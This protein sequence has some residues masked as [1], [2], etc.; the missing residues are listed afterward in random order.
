MIKI[1]KEVFLK[2]EKKH[3]KKLVILFSGSTLSLFLEFFTLASLLPVINILI[4][5]ENSRI[6]Y[7][8][9]DFSNIPLVISIFVSAIL[10]STIY[11]LW[12][13]KVSSKAIFKIGTEI[14]DNIFRKVIRQKYL[15]YKKFKSE[16]F[17]SSITK[18]NSLIGGIILPALLIFFS[19]LMVIGSFSFLFLT[20]NKSLII[21]CLFYLSAY[22]IFAYFVRKKLLDNGKIIAKREGDRVALSQTALGDIRNI[23]LNNSYKKVE[24]ENY[25]MSNSQNIAKAT[26][27]FI[28]GSPRYVMEAVLIIIISIFLLRD[29][30]LL[31]KENLSQIAIL[32][33]A[34][35]RVL[36]QIQAFFSNWAVINSN[37]GMASDLI[38]LL[39]LEEEEEF[40]EKESFVFD[41]NIEDELQIEIN[42]ISYGYNDSKLIIDE[43]N[44]SLEKQD[45]LLV[46]GP[47]GSG[48][49]TLIDL[50]LG[51]LKP[52][53][54]EIILKYNKKNI[55]AHNLNTAF[56]GVVSQINY[57][58]SGSIAEIITGKNSLDKNEIDL[59]NH[60][61]SL[62]NCYEFL[63]S[64]PHKSLFDRELFG[65]N[66][67][68]LSGG[69]RQRIAI[70]RA[71]YSSNGLL[72]LD[73][74]TSALDQETE[75][76]VLNKVFNHFNGIIILIAHKIDPLKFNLETRALK[77]INFTDDGI[78][79]LK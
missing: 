47:T 11:R 1:L 24:A 15:F 56:I 33:F 3:Q 36:P 60:S 5:G 9:V 6:S 67:S 16:D 75:T 10:L 64:A 38:E 13:L 25:E 53:S 57:L 59:F 77:Q 63:S 52:N 70:A 49:T 30:N 31:D 73:E 65:Q 48:K 79:K 40:E 69:Q 2:F 7:F 26:N 19:L 51:L 22:L 76:E 41:S 50:I 68:R 72:I 58:P 43:L 27:I 78:T 39:S 8:N 46:S 12:F 37:T 32:L 4:E 14:S 54:G 28:N 74:P 35:Q 42:N 34:F 29:V 66:A 71:L 62:S 17:I 23:K 44:I 18:I 55:L 20:I 45:L 61:L 21:F